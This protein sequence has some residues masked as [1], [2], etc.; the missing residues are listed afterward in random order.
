[1]KKIFIA[2]S[3]LLAATFNAIAAE[4]IKVIF[5]T[6]MG[7]DVDDVVALDMFYKYLDAGQVDLLGIIS[8]KRELG[9]VKFIDA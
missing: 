1:M 2:L 3:L 7:N 6:D 9:S 4:P 5:D 8:S